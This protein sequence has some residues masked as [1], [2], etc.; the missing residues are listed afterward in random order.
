MSVFLNIACLFCIGCTFGWLLEAGFRRFYSG[1]NA[2]RRWINPGYLTGPWLPVYGFGLC[3]LYLLANLEPYIPVRGVIGKII[4]ILIMAFSVTAVEY[5]AGLVSLKLLKAK[6][7]DY[8]SEW[9]NIQGII[10]PRFALFWTAICAV[11]LIFIHRYVLI[12]LDWLSAHLIF[13]LF[14]GFYLG[15][16]AVDVIG[17]NLSRRGREKWAVE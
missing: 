5:F 14:I 7:W 15:F 8:S 17:L 10:C 12:L 4:L 13:S 1:N 3:A 2:E 9:G 6:L 16:F 11:Y